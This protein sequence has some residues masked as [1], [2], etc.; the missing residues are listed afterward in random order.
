MALERT[1][2]VTTAL[3]LLNEVG[4]DGLTVRRLADRL[5]VQNPALYWHFKNKQELLDQMAALMLSEA[6]GELAPPVAG[7]E[8][9]AWLTGVAG[10]FHQAL[11]SYRDGARVVATANLIGSEMFVVLDLGLR[12]LQDAG[13]DQRLAFGSL[14]TIFDYALGTAFEAQAEP[15][16]TLTGRH[17]PSEDLTTILDTER[18]PTL[19]AA[20][21]EMSGAAPD[22]R[23]SGFDLGLRLILTGM[24]ATK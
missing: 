23:T 12:V 7:E 11:L 13:F 6:F 4:L 1:T 9:T 24:E 8:W 20:L 15:A 14:V 19:A 21:E 2:V 18:L 16:H 10:R 17:T 5:G 3:A 22:D